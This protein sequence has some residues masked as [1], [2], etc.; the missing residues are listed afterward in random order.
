MISQPTSPVYPHYQSSLPG[1][2][3]PPVNP[4]AGF[5]LTSAV[6]ASAVGIGSN[7]AA[8]QA[9]RQT[10]PEAIVNGA[11]KGVAA[12]AILQF[13]P[14]RS[15]AGFALTAGALAAAGYV[16]DSMMFAGKKQR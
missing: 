15:I 5:L 8:V 6:L 9:G 13:T 12:T 2:T 7:M 16:V 14:R 11:L 3:T 4:S 10:L 1:Q